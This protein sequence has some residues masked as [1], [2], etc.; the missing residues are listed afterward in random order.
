MTARNGSKKKLLNYE[1]IYVAPETSSG[2]PGQGLGQE[3]GEYQMSRITFGMKKLESNKN[4]QI[5]IQSGQTI[6]KFGGQNTQSNSIQYE[7][8]S[9]QILNK[10]NAK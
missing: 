6:G 10:N 9:S 2:T 4:N 1:K 5:T 3:N 7:G 8:I